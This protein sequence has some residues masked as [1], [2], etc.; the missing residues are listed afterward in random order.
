[1][2]ETCQRYAENPEANATHLAGCEACGAL[3]SVLDSEIDSKPVAVGAL[4][5][6]PW[7]GAGYRSWPL[8]IGGTLGVLVIAL[9][10]CAAAGISP[11]RAIAVGFQSY[12]IR[13]IITAID[14]KLRPLGPLFFGAIYLIVNTALVFLLRRAP[15]GIDA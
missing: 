3:Y 1:M 4:P 11:L 6:A 5:L 15:R 7:E 2:N 9:A 14:E 10:L 8:A 12:A 13:A